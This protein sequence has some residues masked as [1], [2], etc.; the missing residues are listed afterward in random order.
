MAHAS[1]ACSKPKVELD[2]H[3]DTCIVGDICLVILDHNRQVIV[4]SYDPKDDHKN[5]KTVDAIVGYQDL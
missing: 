5:F 2:S 1:V 4:Y 3:A